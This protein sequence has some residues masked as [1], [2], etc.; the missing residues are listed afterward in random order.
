MSRR[1]APLVLLSA[2]LGLTACGQGRQDAQIVRLESGVLYR[3]DGP[4]IDAVDPHKAG[5][6]WTQAVTG[7]LFVGLMRRGPDG[8]PQLALAQS[9]EVSRTVWCGPSP[10]A[11]HNG[12]MAGR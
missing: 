3:N 4:E 12:R 7:D 11:M 5:G 10:C 9:Y 6:A 1:F 8:R 2:V